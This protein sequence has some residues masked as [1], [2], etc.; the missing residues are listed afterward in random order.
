L[1]S[2]NL[3]KIGKRYLYAES[4]TSEPERTTEAGAGFPTVCGAWVVSKYVFSS[5]KNG[6]K[7]LHTLNFLYLAMPHRDDNYY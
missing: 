4:R 6:K 7:L 2:C 3:N 5:K 1:S